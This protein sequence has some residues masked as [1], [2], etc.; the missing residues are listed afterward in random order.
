MFRNLALL[1]L[2]ALLTGCA[3]RPINL[4]FEA[5]EP[6]NEAQEGSGSRAVETVV[7]QLKAR[8]SFENARTEDIWDNP[9][10]TLR[11]DLIRHAPGETVYP[12]RPGGEVLRVD[13]VLQDVDKETRF[14]GVLAKIQARG[15][16]RRHVVVPVEEAGRVVFRFT[17][18]QITIER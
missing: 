4:T 18:N 13:T 16:G 11:G 1:L 3:S 9:E 10:G 17:G 15:E 8:E 5:I 14:I 12:S 6:V 2:A 7:Y